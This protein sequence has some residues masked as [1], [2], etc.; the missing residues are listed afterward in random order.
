MEFTPGMD[1]FVGKAVNFIYVQNAGL[2]TY[3]NRASAFR[4][5]VESQ[6]VH[7]PPALPAIKGQS[8]KAVIAVCRIERANKYLK[9]P[10][11]AL[12][13]GL[14]LSDYNSAYFGGYL[15][16]PFRKYGNIFWEYK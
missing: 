14:V 16:T 8:L 5:Q 6:K 2:K 9:F 12:T 13:A 11:E 3:K 4:T 10:S 15:S 7:A 1:G